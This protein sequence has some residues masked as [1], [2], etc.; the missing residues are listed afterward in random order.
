[1]ANR[2]LIQI[3]MQEVILKQN[4]RSCLGTTKTFEAKPGYKVESLDYLWNG[5]GRKTE[6]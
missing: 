6:D 3:N 4:A 2:S 5:W 1:M